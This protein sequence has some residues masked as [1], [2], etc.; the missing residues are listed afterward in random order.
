[1]SDLQRAFLSNHKKNIIFVCLLVFYFLSLLYLGYSL[2]VWED[3]AY[4]LNTTSRDIINVVKQSYNFEGQLPIYFVLLALWRSIDQSIFFAR[5]LSI[6]FIAGSG[7]YFYKLAA[8]TG[9]KKNS[10]WLVTIF[11][12]NPFIVWAAVEIRMYALLILLS[13][14]TIYYFVLYCQKHEKKDLIAFLILSLIGLYTQYF[15]GFLIAALSITFC[16]FKGWKSFFRLCLYFIPIGLLFLPNLFFL[17]QQ[18]S[19]TIASSYKNSFIDTTFHVFSTAQ[20]LLLGI[21]L[22]PEVITNRIIR[23]FFACLL[24]Y[25]YV[26]LYKNSIARHFK[27]KIYNGIL[28]TI[29]FFL[30]LFSIGVYLTDIIFSSK[31]IAVILPLNML[32]FIIFSVYSDKI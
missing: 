11:L 30:I 23:I 29:F 5:L 16:I 1:M 12:L 17:P 6:L 21:N 31:Y 26:I 27:F 14:L 13:V 9:E 2:N 24:L 19:I 18:I 28:V 20:N 3:E 4:S 32:L 7:F 15:F 25:G 8:L 22:V 10:K